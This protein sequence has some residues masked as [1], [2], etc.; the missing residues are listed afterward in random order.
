MSV[1]DDSF[2]LQPPK[3]NSP[4]LMRSESPGGLYGGSMLFACLSAFTPHL[5]VYMHFYLRCEHSPQIKRTCLVNFAVSSG[6][7]CGCRCRLI[8]S[9]LITQLPAPTPATASADAAAPPPT[10][11]TPS[12]PDPHPEPAAL[13][14]SHDPT[15]PAANL[16]PLSRIRLLLHLRTRAAVAAASAQPVPGPQPP[17]ACHP[18]PAS[19]G[20][21][22]KMN[23]KLCTRYRNDSPPPSK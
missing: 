19:V 3:L 5:C 6:L 7:S 18:A 13:P 15:Q 1:R 12:P 10:A 4:T 16:C 23:T 8:N 2:V 17:F 20:E 9:Y 11:A 14:A 21:F 22:Y